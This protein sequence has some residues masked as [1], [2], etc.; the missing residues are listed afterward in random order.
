MGTVPST[1]SVSNSNPKIGERLTIDHPKET[2]EDLT[3]NEEI[4][5]E[6]TATACDPEEPPYLTKNLNEHEKST[7]FTCP[8]YSCV[9][10][11]GKYMRTKNTLVIK[12]IIYEVLVTV[13]GTSHSSD[14][15]N[16][17]LQESNRGVTLKLKSPAFYGC[18][19]II[20][21][22]RHDGAKPGDYVEFHLDGNR[23]RWKWCN[24]RRQQ[25][26]F[27]T[28]NTSNRG[29]VSIKYLENGTAFAKGNEVVQL[30]YSLIN[31]VKY[32]HISKRVADLD[33]CVTLT[34]QLVHLPPVCSIILRCAGIRLHSEQLQSLSGE[35]TIR[36]PRIPCD[37]EV[38]CIATED[39]STVLALESLRVM[40]KQNR[41]VISLVFQGH[42][43]DER[44]KVVRP[45]TTVTLAATGG[46]L[47]SADEVLILRSDSNVTNFFSKPSA[48]AL[49]VPINSFPLGQSGIVIVQLREEGVYSL[50]LGVK[51]EQNNLL[52][53]WCNL[54]VS[55]RAGGEPLETSVN[56]HK[57]NKSN[58][59][60]NNSS[61]SVTLPPRRR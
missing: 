33:E 15:I 11:V 48:T 50:C 1:F 16:S 20:E 3:E 54:I 14:L 22:T 47:N 18:P 35:L 51:F 43:S 57:K 49:Q 38:A 13:S 32:F 19:Q 58:N 26:N 59:S 44:I 23:D 17:N 7:Q 5:L 12:K 56:H 28:K 53:D 39:G 45:G 21:Y 31:P 6:I 61:T 42:R 55:E 4:I 24:D 36:C 60:I 29:F 41:A 2:N 37:C 9:L 10:L 40:D 27:G 52:G 46:I 34:Y 25:I 8:Y 30:N